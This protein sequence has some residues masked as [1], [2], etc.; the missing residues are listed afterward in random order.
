M[1]RQ[2]RDGRSAPSGERSGLLVQL[3]Q[4]GV[5]ATETVGPRLVAEQH[6]RAHPGLASLE[7]LLV[8][9]LDPGGLDVR[10]AITGK[11]QE[12]SLAEAHVVVL[13]A[14]HERLQHRGRWLAAD[15]R[16][17]LRHRAVVKQAPLP[18]SFTSTG[19][20]VAAALVDV[21][22]ATLS[23]NTPRT[24]TIRRATAFRDITPHQIY[25]CR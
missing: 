2:N 25:S 24:T 21:P 16:P 12:E 4:A 14:G 18:S 5:L 6:E 3:N 17:N 20:R 9:G 22:M 15:Q 11:V 10:A 8:E 23:A 19:S 13:G 1:A 7:S